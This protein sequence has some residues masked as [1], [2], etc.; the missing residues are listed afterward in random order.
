[1]SPRFPLLQGVGEARKRALGEPL[2]G[3]S[4]G[5]PRAARFLPDS[6]DV[7]TPGGRRGEV[8][9]PCGSDGRR[10]AGVI[11]GC[12]GATVTG[13]QPCCWS[14]DLESCACG[15]FAAGARSAVCSRQMASSSTAEGTTYEGIEMPTLPCAC[16][17]DQS[18]GPAQDPVPCTPVPASPLRRNLT[19]RGGGDAEPPL[20]GFAG[21]TQR[22][23]LLSCPVSSFHLCSS[24]YIL[25][26]S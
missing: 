5:R 20:R 8:G 26:S 1:M 17:E 19:P 25:S 7:F 16:R 9:A 12:P 4:L 15:G 18:H 11:L 6:C 13:A 2:L 10:V 3:R 22:A 21:T 24:G 23:V 14:P